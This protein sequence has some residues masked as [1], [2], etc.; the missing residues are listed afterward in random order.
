M[1]CGDVNYIDYDV[2]PVFPHEVTLTFDNIEVSVIGKYE[3]LPIERTILESEEALNVEI[4]YDPPISQDQ[5]LEK[6]CVKEYRVIVS[7]SGI[8]VDTKD[9]SNLSD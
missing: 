5:N 8:F 3:Q 7:C 9:D 2:P 6:K 1:L 4:K